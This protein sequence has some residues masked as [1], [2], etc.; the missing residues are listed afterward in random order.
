MTI[1]LTV[2]T[3]VHHEIHTA[4]KLEK[5]SN[6]T[7]QELAFGNSWFQFK[8]TLIQSLIRH[9][10]IR[11]GKNIYILCKGIFMDVKN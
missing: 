10:A 1:E 3:E 6:K 8:S 5:Q 11:N 4:G 7:S 9:N 2:R